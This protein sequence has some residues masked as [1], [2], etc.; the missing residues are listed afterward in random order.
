MKNNY[1]L[2]PNKF[3][4][5]A[6]FLVSIKSVPKCTPGYFFDNPNM[7]D[8]IIS[9]FNPKIVFVERGLTLKI[10]FKWT[11]F[12]RLGHITFLTLKIYQ[13][14]LFWAKCTVNN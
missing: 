3:V 5:L 9:L 14:V 4:L 1:Y 13:D 8:P 12:S 2:D 7:K 11:I 10:G 6:H